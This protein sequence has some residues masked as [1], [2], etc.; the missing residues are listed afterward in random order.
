MIIKKGWV[1]MAAALA[2]LLYVGQVSANTATSSDFDG[3]GVVG[4]PDFLEFVEKFGSRQGDEKYD[5]KY[6]LDGNG[7]IGIP[8]FLIFVDNFGK[9][10][11]V[12]RA[13]VFEDARANRALDENTLPGEKVGDPIA[14][15]GLDSLTYRLS[16]AQADSFAIDASTGQ[17]RTRE[18]VRYDYERK[19]TY[20]MYVVVMDQSDSDPDSIV[21]VITLND[22]KEPPSLPPSSFLVVPDDQSLSVHY[23]QVHDK[24]GRPPVRGYHAE[25]RK[26]ED[27]EWGNRKTIY[28]RNNTT[29]YYHKLDVPRYQNPYLVNG[30]LYQVRVRSWN[31]DG[32]SAWSEPVSGT[33]EPRPPPK[34]K[35]VYSV[36]PPVVFQDNTSGTETSATISIS[37]STGQGGMVVVPKAALPDDIKDVVEAVFVEIAQISNAPAV[38]SN[39]GFALL[40]SSPIFDIIV[41][42]R[43]A[44]GDEVDIGDDLGEPVEICLPVPAN[45]S[46]PVIVHY[47]DGTWQKLATLRVEGNTICALVNSFSSFAVG[48]GDSFPDGVGENINL[49]EKRKIAEFLFNS[50]PANY[51]Y[52]NYGNCPKVSPISG[53]CHRTNGYSG[54]RGGH[55]GWDVQTQSVAQKNT[56]D[57]LF[58]SLTPGE[59]IA[60]GG[61]F[62]KIAV[63][64]EGKTILYLHARRID[65]TVGK[66]IDVGTRLGI[67]GNVGLGSDP[68]ENEHV[69]IEVRKGSTS[70]SAFG[71]D[72]PNNPNPNIAPVEYL[73]SVLEKHSVDQ[74]VSIP[75]ANAR[76]A[77]EM[78][79]GKSSGAPIT[80]DEM[81]TLTRLEAPNSHISDLTGLEF[82]TRLKI[83]NFGNEGGQNSNSIMDISALSGLNSLTYLNLNQNSIVDISPLSGLTNLTILFLSVNPIVDISPL[84]GLTSLTELG[85][86]HNSIVDISP[87]SGLTNLTT[88]GLGNPFTGLPFVSN[89]N[90]I[91]DISPL[92]SMTSLTELFLSNNSITDISPLSG[93]TSLTEL[94]LSNNSI[95]DLAPLVANTGLGSGD[96]VDVRTNPLSDASINTHIPALQGRGVRVQF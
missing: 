51:N 31:T 94:D 45:T 46:N 38:P 16:G 89:N 29:F 74:P 27:G 18:G 67:Q 4:I 66:T 12:R 48:N 10:V 96:R 88:L 80:K 82:A 43:L 72:Y 71:A 59:V 87:L 52:N 28:G 17:I 85:L 41:K 49:K 9:A 1:F 90:S 8:D 78:F 70:S 23:A 47:K 21:V 86:L 35:V 26:G 91:T 75:N 32:A 54:Y 2:V 58:Y 14:V 44:S 36:T 79:L 84:S 57:E 95:S 24:P 65:V 15:V 39:A 42:V 64:Y 7:E 76:A 53:N 56:A 30:Q 37:G 62:S 6:D 34:P 81:T 40:D 93:M 50:E 73:Y 5:A 20:L 63:Y 22:V 25:L 83:L 69:H 13:P 68:N 33:P 77:I 19:K 61:E 55:A 60:I 3:D 92:S 11:P